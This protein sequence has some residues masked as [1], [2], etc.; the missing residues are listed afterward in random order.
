M[1][2][3]DDDV[4]EEALN[5][6]GR[7]D[8]DLGDIGVI[9][10]IGAGSMGAGIAQVALLAGHRVYLHDVSPDQVEH[11]VTSIEARLRAQVDKGRLTHTEA[12]AA[13][14]RLGVVPAIEDLPECELVVEAV[15]ED[16]ALKCEIFAELARHQTP[17]TILATN[18]SS[19]DVD[20]I[21]D[22]VQD[23]ER[24]LGLHFFNPAP[25][26]E[27]VE[28]VR[29]SWTSD[30]YLDFA[31][32]LVR[33]W[34]KSPVTC[35][36]TPGFIVNRVARPFYG[37]AQRMLEEGVADA[38]TLDACLRGAGFRM[39]PLEL[40]D[41]IGQDVN[42]A[43]GMSVWQQTDRDPRYAPTRLQQDLVASGRLG[44]KTGQGIYTYASGDPAGRAQVVGATPDE[45]RVAELVGGPVTT[46]PVARTLAMLV[47]E[48]VD[49]VHR[50][51][52]SAQDVD[53]AMV[54]GTAYPKGPLAWGRELG[55]DVVRHTLEELDAAYPGGRYRPSP[56][57][58]TMP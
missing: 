43:V 10:V 35:A 23:P 7:T 47:N 12:D 45:S 50:G 26:M 27:L 14:E 9:G 8:A 32:S 24:V 38:A 48:A 42:L 49:L 46:D 51:E 55:H 16:L 1:V 37:E 18:T 15:R 22:R 3:Q 2:R 53:T 21:A 40:T 58:E 31:R 34:G 20:E 28:V 4:V 56:A 25:V 30:I 11:A 17:T 19:L 29:G 41:L 33:R 13:V 57:L 6:E 44:R 52:A 54:L 39:G 36:S 5:G